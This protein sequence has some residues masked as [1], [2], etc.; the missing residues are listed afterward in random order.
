MLSIF[1]IP[2]QLT[3]LFFFFEGTAH[4]TRSPPS[5]FVSFVWILSFMLTTGNAFVLEGQGNAKA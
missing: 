2:T 5:F 1:Y 3:I 4:N